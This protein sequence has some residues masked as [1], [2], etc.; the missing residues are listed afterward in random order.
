MTSTAFRVELERILPAPPAEVFRAWT[1]PERLRVFMCPGA[2]TSADV[3]ADV[4]V[5]GRFR[6][7]M[8]EGDAAI[9]HTGEYRVVDPPKRLVFTWHSPVTGPGGSLV[10]I[11]LAAHPDGTRLVL[12]HEALPSD[13][14]AGKHQ[15]GWGSIVEKLARHLGAAKENP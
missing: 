15:R 5:G 2:I 3:E 13:D 14:A 7:V 10:T 8:H 6:I 9:A 12:T 1:D 4:R 11:A